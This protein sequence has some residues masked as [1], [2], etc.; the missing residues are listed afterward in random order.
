MNDEPTA[1]PPPV[2][3]APGLTIVSAS[4]L[5]AP[6]SAAGPSDGPDGP[7]DP[8]STSGSDRPPRGSAAPRIIARWAAVAALIGGGLTVQQIVDA[9]PSPGEG[10]LTV[11]DSGHWFEY[12]NSGEPYF[13]AGAGGPDDFLFLS[14]ERRQDIVDQ[15][16]EHDVRSVSVAAVRSNGGEGDSTDNPFV[17]SSEPS[18]GVDD[19][20][21]DDWD[22]FLSQL[23]EAGIVTWFHLYDS[24]AR[25]FGACTV[26][27]PADEREFVKTLVERFREY[28]HLV[29]LPTA[30]HQ[31]GACS[32]DLVD[33]AKVEALAAEIRRHDDVHPLAV[34]HAVGQP[35]Q[36]VGN[37][38]ID[39]FAQQGCGPT[40]ALSV[41]ATHAQGAYG[42]DVYVHS[43]CDP[44]HRELLAAGD[45]TTL[46]R[47]WWSSVMAGGYVLF[48]GA[49][50]AGDP[51][52]GMLADLGRINEFMD[53]TRFSEM[54]PLDDLAALDTTWVLGNQL[55]DVYVLYSASNPTTVGVDGVSSGTYRLDW[56]D[57]ATGR[58]VAEIANVTEETAAFGVPSELGPEVVVHVE[59]ADDLPAS[60][61]TSTTTTLA[62]TT[63][64][65]AETT[66]AT[67]GAPTNDVVP[68]TAVPE[69][70]PVDE[71]TTTTST[72]T[73]VAATT[74]TTTAPATT[75]TSSTSASSTTSPATT[76]TTTAPTTIPPTTS[77][78]PPAA[79]ST[80]ED[81]EPAPTEPVPSAPTTTSEVTPPTE[82]PVPPSSGPDAGV[83]RLGAV[84]DAYLQGS[85]GVD[86]VRLRVEA[87]DSGRVS[88]VRFDTAAVESAESVGLQLVVADDPG[89]G[90]LTIALGSDG[91]WTEL[92]LTPDTAPTEGE[93][94]ATVSGRFRSGNVVAVDLPSHVVKGDVLDLVLRIDGADAADVA[95]VATEG[96][97]GPTLVIDG[98]TKMP[99]ISGRPGSE[100]DF[101]PTESVDS[102]LHSGLESAQR[103]STS[104]LVFEVGTEVGDDAEFA[105]ELTV[106]RRSGRASISV[107]DGSGAPAVPAVGAEHEADADPPHEQAEAGALGSAA[108][109][110]SPG[111]VVRVPVD[112]TDIGTDGTVELVVEVDGPAARRLEFG[113]ASSEAPP[114]LVQR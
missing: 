95:F 57:P 19:D 38:D 65:V 74:S 55:A 79:S 3:G 14:D 76:S 88:Y 85:N 6:R 70:E 107:W 27:L 109:R 4:D 67:T 94:L 5:P 45:R 7:D 16:I 23:D 22:R 81:T 41:D 60:T 52:P 82:A 43:S 9:D 37:P 97:E 50:D 62:P 49:W 21:L 87:G 99:S 35:A 111:D 71:P 15:L 66:P 61:T 104:S 83:L 112:S 90:T 13:L 106:Q 11:D 54:G 44:W 30:D 47:S 77:T 24:G 17:V 34:Q 2:V 18:S 73:S 51:S 105:L 114:R 64:A 103:T 29:W 96:G 63:D 56:F 42:D 12:E 98:A 113:T 31:A 72:T 25:P 68:S 92:T 110:F 58:R 32:D 108:G 101:V 48:S 89:R 46:R 75:A 8:A 102:D 10:A 84:D 53:S 100:T 91:D 78:E 69:P 33:L 86:E 1:L 39:V 59:R 40:D 26:D 20:V 36:Y 80:T 93:V 28:R